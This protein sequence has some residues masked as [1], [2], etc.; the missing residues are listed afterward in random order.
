MAL[1]SGCYYDNELELYGAPSCDTTAVSYSLFVE[2]I[3]SDNCYV[4]HSAA[5]NFGG[6]TLEGY[7]A[8]KVYVNN[9]RLLGAIKHAP[10]FSAMPQG[11]PKLP[12]CTIN[13]IEAWIDA[14]ALNN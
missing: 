2:N 8:T 1:F 5:A 14:G 12:D 7:D 11:A 10:D 13:K 6:V 3:M 4:C 9:G